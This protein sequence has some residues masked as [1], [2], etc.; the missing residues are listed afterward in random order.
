MN[1]QP[2]GHLYG[3]PPPS[4]AFYYGDNYLGEVRGHPLALDEA[5]AKVQRQIE[6]M[7]PGNVGPSLYM[8]RQARAVLY[9]GGVSLDVAEIRKVHAQRQREQSNLDFCL[10]MKGYSRTP[11]NDHP[12]YVMTVVLS[13]DGQYAIGLVKSKG[14]AKLI[15]KITF[16]GGRMAPGE[17]PRTA[18][19][20]ELLEETGVH[21]TEDRLVNIANSEEMAVFAAR[22]SDVLKAFTREQEEVLVLAVPRQLEYRRRHPDAYVPEFSIFLEAAAAALPI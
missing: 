8:L 16:P 10:L 19:A 6:V 11:R 1:T 15:G 21:V 5:L 13:D 3:P 18:A 9:C 7:Q 17:S 22:S 12:K 4:I 2:P 20:R 14:P